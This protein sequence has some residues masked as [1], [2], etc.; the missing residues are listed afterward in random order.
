MEQFFPF[1]IALF[2]GVFFSMFS[3]KAH[4]PWVVAL[5][6]GGV[7][8]GPNFLNILELNPTIMFIGQ[9]GLIFLMFMAGL[10]TKFQDLEGFKGK[11]S[12]L[13]FINGVIPFGVGVW[14]ALFLGYPLLPALILGV[15][16]I[17]SSIAV[18]VPSL[19]SHSILNTR[20]GQSVVMTTVI[21]DVA[22]LIALSLVLQNVNT[23]T[24]L[25]L[26]LFY[27]LLLVSLIVLRFIIKMIR[28]Y[29]KLVASEKPD[30]FQFE[31][32]STF[33]IMMGTVLV[34]EFLGLHPIV[35][36]F[37]SGLVLSGSIQTKA[38]KDKIRTI[39]YGVFIPTFFIVIGLQTDIKVF[40]EIENVSFVVGLIIFGSV[41]SKFI[42][43]WIGAKIVGFNNN[44]SLLFAITSIPQLSTTL[45]TAS[46]A[47]ALG[48]IDQ[49]LLTALVMLSISTVL[50]S[51]ILM[52]IFST[53]IEIAGNK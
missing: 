17:S 26:Y 31:F 39:S 24:F 12:L 44:E 5:I 13:A 52:N 29:F 10:E 49:V 35:A 1:F 38:L 11:L 48:L 46:A 53:R 33:L 3:R 28:G 14:V 41:V 32:R 50:I 21:Q 30:M 37:F 40:S 4:I 15:V 42:S 25:P 43:G 34:F 23:I 2:A 22:S 8:L 20:L 18:V 51:P 45:A 7:L 6:G 16:F 9:I 36:G 47:F 19:E 27:P